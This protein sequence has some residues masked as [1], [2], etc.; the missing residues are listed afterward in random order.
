MAR[1]DTLGHFLTDVADAIREKTGSSDAIAAE[2]FDTEI[3]NIPSGGGTVEEKD[4]NFYD[5]DGILVNSYSKSEFLA[6]SA[7]PNNPT[8]SGL[9]SQGWNWSLSDAKT[10]VTSYDKLDIGQMYDT[11][12]GSVRIYIKLQEG[13]LSP[14]LGFAI[15]GTATVDWGDNTATDTVTG[16]RTTTPK[17][18]LHNYSQAGEYVI[19][20]TSE[21]TIYIVGDS[22]GTYLLTANGSISNDYRSIAYRNSVI[23]V[24]GLDSISNYAFANCY[25]LLSVTISSGS[26]TNINDSS[27]VNCYNLTH[28]T[29][30]SNVTRI[31]DYVFQNCYN[32]RHITIP[33]TV[34]YIGGN[35]FYSCYSLFDITIPSNVTTIGTYTFCNCYTLLYA[36]MPSSIT[37][38]G[39]HVFDSCYTLSSITIPSISNYAFVNCSSLLDITI[40][41]NVTSISNNAFKSCYNL[42]HVTIPSTVTTIVNNAFYG[43]YPV[44]YYDFSNHTS[45]PTL[46]H[47]NAFI[48][49]ASD[50]KIIVPDDLYNDWIAENNWS[51]YASYIIKKSDWDNL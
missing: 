31:G 26:I 44:A 16:T 34:T 4:V 45:I 10:Y 29:I 30:P 39:E 49:I 27:F 24:Y 42:T 32:L 20:I 25:S 50:C 41:S 2:D 7:M 47:T 38:V 5:Y 37:S 19:T 40:L 13:R 17:F 8:H 46:V 35:A 6:L 21:S 3:E 23:R 11:D 33:S 1:I 48:N 36:I 15:N 9:T 12:D 18:T 14:Y 28:L 43:C 51:T 22:Y